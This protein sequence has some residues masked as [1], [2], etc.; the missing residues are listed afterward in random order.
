VGSS[1]SNIVHQGNHEKSFLYLE[2]ALHSI[3]YDYILYPNYAIL[4][5]GKS[6]IICTME[7][8]GKLCNGE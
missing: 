3:I 2:S 7:N 4:L 1:K 5:L 8:E 6:F